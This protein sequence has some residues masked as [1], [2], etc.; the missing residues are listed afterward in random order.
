M[1]AGANAATFLPGMRLHGTT[2]LLVEDDVDNLE[3]LASGLEEAGAHVV[4][5]SSVGSALAAASAH[6][7]DVLVS[8]MELPDGDGC[9][10][11]RELRQRDGCRA[12]P[13]IA[14]SGYSDKLWRTQATGV[15]F[16]RYAIKPFSMDYLVDLVLLLRRGGD[17]QGAT[18]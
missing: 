14:V 15:G 16:N 17:D 18:L 2:V 4:Q 8:D 6:R 9:A 3:M 12:L 1:R 7:V 13:A 10:L 5:A 11:L